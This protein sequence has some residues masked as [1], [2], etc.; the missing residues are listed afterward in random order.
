MTG[1]GRAALF[2]L[3]TILSRTALIRSGFHLR[4]E[5]DAKNPFLRN[6]R[7]ARTILRMQ[8]GSLALHLH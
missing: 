2:R 4:R 3:L 5:F 7:L 8:R 1:A 6:S